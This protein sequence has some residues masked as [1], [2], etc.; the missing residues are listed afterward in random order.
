VLNL[1][2]EKAHFSCGCSCNSFG[3]LDFYSHSD[4]GPRRFCFVGRLGYKRD[5]IQPPIENESFSGCADGSYYQHA[6]M[7]L[8]NALAVDAGRAALFAFSHAWPRA[9]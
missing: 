4:K 9:T 7:M 3:S 1:K 5:F 2:Y 8:P 6:K